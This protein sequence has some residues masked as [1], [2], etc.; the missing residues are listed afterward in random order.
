MGS[1][2]ELVQ[3]GRARFED[4]PAGSLEVMGFSK[5]T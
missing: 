3:H 4:I 5:S 1:R 2:V